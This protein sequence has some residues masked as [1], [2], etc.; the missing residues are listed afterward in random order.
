MANKKHTA[1]TVT[2]VYAA[3][4]DAR[5]VFLVG[6]FNDW[7]ITAKRMMRRKDGTFR[8]RVRLSPGVYQY[9]YYVDGIWVADPGAER[10]AANSYGT[11]N[12]VV[13]VE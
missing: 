10:K 4:P 7:D 2:F 3:A 12:S 6:D 1:R 13:I 5:K 9:K 11:V 8:G